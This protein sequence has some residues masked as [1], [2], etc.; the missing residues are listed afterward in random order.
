MPFGDMLAH[1]GIRGFAVREGWGYSAGPGPQVLDLGA[2]GRVLPLICYEAVFPRN[3]AAA[4]ERPMWILQITNDG[5]FGEVS[6]PFQHL[7]QARLRA[8]EFGLPVL[9]AA[10][11]GVSAVIDAHGRLRATLP[12]GTHGAIDAFVPRPLAPT[13]YARA[14]DGPLALLLAAAFAGLALGRRRG[15]DP[16]RGAI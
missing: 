13:P 4:P 15:L 9:R 1:A 6:G 10:N 3:I 12:L 7:A 11:T 16:A 8:V 5:W 2:A 14:G